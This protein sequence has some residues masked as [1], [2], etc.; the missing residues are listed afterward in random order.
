[1]SRSIKPALLIASL[2]FVAACEK[3]S[4]PIRTSS[5]AGTKTS[6]SGDAANARSHSL[7]RVVNATSD[8]KAVSVGLG[9]DIR[10]ADVRSGIVTDYREVDDRLTQFNVSATTPA[11]GAE[12]D[13]KNAMLLDGE[14]YTAFVI[15]Q[16]VSRRSIRV[17]RDDV[18]P[19]SGKARL[20]VVH[21]APGGPELDVRAAGAAERM[22]TGVNF[23]SEAGFA[24]IAPTALALEIRA[25]GEDRILLR[26]PTMQLRK[27]T[28]T[29]VVVT[30]SG[31]LAFF[32][33][34]DAMMKR[35]VSQ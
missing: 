24:D 2:L 22:F 28:A 12:P 19:D 27:G 6:P 31:K 21:A 7:V 13:T 15:S 8:G 34:N 20:R 18:I 3:D 30:G 35:V 10:F 11:A 5:D 4:S 33:F 25:N 14:R 29:T 17:V 9:E 16:D 26:V 1:M 32:V 23:T